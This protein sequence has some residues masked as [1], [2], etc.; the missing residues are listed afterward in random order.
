MAA[1]GLIVG[2]GNPGAKY[3]NNRHNVGFMFVDQLAAAQQLELRAHTRW[4]GQYALWRHAEG[5]AH[6]LKPST[7][8][9]LSGQ[10]VA[11]CVRYFQVA[12][13][14][15]LV[16]HDEIDFPSS[17]LRLKFG[18]GSGGHNGLNDIMRH[19]GSRDFWRLRVGV[20]RPTDRAQVKN[21][22]LSDFSATELPVLLAKLER[23]R[24]QLHL[25]LAGQTQQA[26]QKIAA[27]DN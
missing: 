2:L 4:R 22:V 17:R 5:S 12:P 3:S 15:I 19:L 24:D 7:Y 14:Q 13:E 27:L 26:Q 11:A 1:I 25:L 18:G 9:N 8:M 10:A 6:L 23:A 20:G 16:V 21:Y